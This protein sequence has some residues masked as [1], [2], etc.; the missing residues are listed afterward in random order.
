MLND[1]GARLGWRFDTTELEGKPPV[2][3]VRTLVQVGI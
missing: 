3:I 2:V 1:Y